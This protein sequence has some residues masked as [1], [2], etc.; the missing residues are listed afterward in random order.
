MLKAF[1]NKIKIWHLDKISIKW[2]YN[3]DTMQAFQIIS[4]KKSICH[5]IIFQNVQLIF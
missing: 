2:W 5:K 3:S 4:R 1:M